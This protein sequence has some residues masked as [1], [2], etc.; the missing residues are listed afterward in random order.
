MDSW[1]RFHVTLENGEKV[2]GL[3]NKCEFCYFDS[4][5]L[6]QVRFISSDKCV[7]E[8]TIYC[9]NR[10]VSITLFIYNITPQKWK[11]KKSITRVSQFK[12]QKVI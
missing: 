9:I 4:S 7:F 5:N 12:L 1:D 8:I 2:R 10:K 6:F 3:I 11:N